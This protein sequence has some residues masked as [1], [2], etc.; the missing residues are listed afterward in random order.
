MLEQKPSLIVHIRLRQA[1]G[2]PAIGEYLWME[3]LAEEAY[4]VPDQLTDEMGYA[5]GPSI[6]A[7]TSCACLTGP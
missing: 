3:H 1:N 6:L 4:S 2:Q 7:Y 5:V